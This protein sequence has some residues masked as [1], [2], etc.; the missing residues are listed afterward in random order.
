[1]HYLLTAL[2]LIASAWTAYSILMRNA[3]PSG[4]TDE[5]YYEREG[6]ALLLPA[7]VLGGL[8]FPLTWFVW[9]CQ[10]DN[11]TGRP[12]TITITGVLTVASTVAVALHPGSEAI[13][14]AF[15]AF[16]LAWGLSCVSFFLGRP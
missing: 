5:D 16:G 14:A 9:S 3:S 12:W 6:S 15:C 2:Y 7:A 11:I 4:H 8:V 1:M 13:Y 10:N